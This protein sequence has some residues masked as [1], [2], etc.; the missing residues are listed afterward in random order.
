MRTAYNSGFELGHM[1]NKRGVSINLCLLTYR[2][3]RTPRGMF[4]WGSDIMRWAPNEAQHCRGE[5]HVLRQRHGSAISF[6]HW[7]Y[8]ALA[9]KGSVKNW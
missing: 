8:L 2:G 5:A 1:C 4:S 3:R 9:E 7:Q 6:C